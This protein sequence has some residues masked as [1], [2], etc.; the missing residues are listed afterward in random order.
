MKKVH[1]LLLAAMLP[2][3]GLANAAFA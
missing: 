2:V 1:Y 3:A